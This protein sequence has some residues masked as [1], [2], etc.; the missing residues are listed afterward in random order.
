[1]LAT[2]SECFRFRFLT[3]GSAI[4]L[5]AYKQVLKEV[6]VKATRLGAEVFALEK[7]EPI[8]IYLNP[9]SKAD[10]LVAINTTASSSTKDENAAVSFRGASA[11]ATGYFLNGVPLKNPVKYAQLTNTG[12]LS[13]FNTDFLKNVTVFPGNPPVEYGQSTSGTI[14]LEMADR[15]PDYAQHTASISMASLGYSYRNKIGNNTYLGLYSNYQFDA[16]LRFVNPE[17]FENI[18]SFESVDAGLLLV[19]HQTWGSVKFYQYGLLDNYN[20][21]FEHPSYQN[22][23]IQE[24]KRSIS[25][26]K[27]TQEF[28]NT[29]LSAVIGNTISENDFDFGNIQFTETALEPYAAVHF[30]YAKELHLWKSGYS[31][32]SQNSA[33]LGTFPSFSF[34]LAPENPATA[35][36][37]SL[38]G[39]M[40]EAY[41]FYRLK[42]DR[43]AIA[44][45]VRLGKIAETGQEQAGY[46]V[47]IQYDIT[48]KI[49]VK[50]GNGQYYQMRI[51]DEIAINSSQQTAIDLAY[52]SKKFAL[53]QSF[54]SNKLDEAIRLNGSE[55]TFTYRPKSVLQFNQSVSFI[56]NNG[57]Y[58]W[59]SRSTAEY[60][61]ADLWSASVIYQAYRGLSYFMLQQATFN[62]E[63]SLYEPQ[64]ASQASFFAPYQN[65][66]LS[67]N[68][69]I[70]FT[71]KLSGIAFATVSNLWDQ[72]NTVSLN[73]SFNYQSQTENYL[74][75]RSYLCRN[76]L[77]F[78]KI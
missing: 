18:N 65:F 1:M 49:D 50:I 64:F 48:S 45:G 63:L 35:F 4:G 41:G 13:I 70:Q 19:S 34:A 56:E 24:A 39:S 57:K 15:F 3:A 33:G 52:N 6:A 60:Q 47:N 43:T 21:N 75:R 46:Q 9:V 32:W 62:N 74:T 12:T 10:P 54:Y 66:S 5:Y 31:Y 67:I 26:L 78:C 77:K 72:K 76:N 7:L 44:A 27:W 38:R 68:R 22:N 20:F 42:L 29:Q 36:D 71:D 73:Y 30:T 37:Q 16:A 23:F 28:G 14:V 8:D 40:H 25:T 53:A 11:N 17:N 2:G 51:E 58:D 61:F 69:L 55:T 59:F